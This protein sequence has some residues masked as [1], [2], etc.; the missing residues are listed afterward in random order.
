[1]SDKE[2]QEKALEDYVNNKMSFERLAEEMGI[3]F[4]VLHTAFMHY[5]KP[6]P[7]LEEKVAKTPVKT[8]KYDG[9]R[10]LTL[11]LTLLDKGG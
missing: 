8:H 5:R 10:Y 2:A 4:Y 3:N 7:E 9:K 6:S 1:M 11:S